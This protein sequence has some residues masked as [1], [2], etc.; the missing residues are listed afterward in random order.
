[1]PSMHH[2]RN[3]PGVFLSKNERYLYAFGGENETIERLDLTIKPDD[4]TSRF[5]TYWDIVDVKLPSQ[6]KSKCGFTMMP[7]WKHFM[8]NDQLLINNLDDVLI[9]G[10]YQK[11]IFIYDYDKNIIEP[12]KRKNF[13]LSI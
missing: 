6:L 13:G 1:M 9:L 4:Y 10:G 5:M 8:A 3:F 2:E 7:V 12:F 11:D